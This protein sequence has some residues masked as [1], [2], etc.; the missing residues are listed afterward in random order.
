MSEV[1]NQNKK[2]KVTLNYNSNMVKEFS[3]PPKMSEKEI[4]A[5]V[6]KKFGIYDVKNWVV[7]ES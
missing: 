7:T 6:K 1:A 5:W 4:D 2:L 3:I